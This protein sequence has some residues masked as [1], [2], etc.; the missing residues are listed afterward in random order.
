MIPKCPICKGK[1]ISRCG[2]LKASSICEN[3]HKF[4]FAVKMVKL[5]QY[6]VEIHEG[7]GDHFTDTCE[8]CVVIVIDKQAVA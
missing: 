7:F 6:D 3:D 4:H 5:N 1:V 8:D 2:C